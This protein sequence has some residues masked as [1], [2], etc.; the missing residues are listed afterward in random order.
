MR[1]LN[2]NCEVPDKSVFVRNVDKSLKAEIPTGDG[3]S[4][5]MMD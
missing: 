5:R 1:C 3:L 2:C 4:L